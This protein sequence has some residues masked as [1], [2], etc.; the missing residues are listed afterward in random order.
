MSDSEVLSENEM[1]ALMNGVSDGEVEA[2]TGIETPPGTVEKYD[3]AHPS[4][5]L[6]SRLPVLDVINEK[7]AK[8]LS[9]SLSKAFHQEM[10]VTAKTPGFEKYQ[11]YAHSLPESVSLSQFKMEP[12]QG[13]AFLCLE[14]QLI[15]MLVDTF[16]GGCGSLESALTV[17][18]FTPT[19]QRIIDRT[20]D[21]IFAA[22]VS[23]WTPVLAIEPVFH[24]VLSNSQITSPGNP[25]AV[26]V[27]LKF[28]IELASGSGE[29]HIVTPFSML[30]PLRPQL[31]ND[32]QKMRGH[33]AKWLQAFTERVKDS[34]L[35]IEGVIGETEITL[36]QLLNLKAG[37]FIPLG[38]QQTVT[39]SSEGIPLFDAVVGVSNGLV[40][41]SLSQWH[42]PV[43]Q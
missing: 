14:G 12:L 34:E 40:S 17:R 7:M 11:D 20:R 37:D 24:S 27:T 39:F 25:S 38:Q 32:L 6:N 41:A 43:R 22:M 35:G 13:N 33:D 36:S 29:C 21:L 2:E 8:E 10:K 4:H 16:F 42:R 23:A 26:V 3:F 28:D 5:K 1:D 30:E 18:D 15:F 9:A 19:E 31:T